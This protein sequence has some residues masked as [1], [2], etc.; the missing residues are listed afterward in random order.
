MRL[1]EVA[2][3]MACIGCIVARSVLGSSTISPEAQAIKSK[4][5]NI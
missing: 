2:R 1:D 5:N 4:Q 3:V